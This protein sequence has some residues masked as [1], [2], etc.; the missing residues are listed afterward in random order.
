MTWFVHGFK[1]ASAGAAG[2]DNGHG[3]WVKNPGQAVWYYNIEFGSVD[4][5]LAFYVM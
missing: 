1:L 4:N 3:M 2:A 5:V